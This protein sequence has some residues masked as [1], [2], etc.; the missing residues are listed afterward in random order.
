MYVWISKWTVLLFMCSVTNNVTSEWCV[1][2]RTHSK[3]GIWNQ[4][5][6][7]TRLDWNQSC[8]NMHQV[9]KFCSIILQIWEQ[10]LFTLPALFLSQRIFPSYNF[11]SR[12]TFFAYVAHSAGM[13]VVRV[14]TGIWSFWPLA[15]LLCRPLS[16]PRS[17]SSVLCC[18]W[19]CISYS[20]WLLPWLSSSPHQ[21]CLR[22]G[23]SGRSCVE[24]WEYLLFKGLVPYAVLVRGEQRCVFGRGR[25]RADTVSL[26]GRASKSHSRLPPHYLFQSGKAQARSHRSSVCVCAWVCGL[27]FVLVSTYVYICICEVLF[28]VWCVCIFR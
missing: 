17:P 1:D 22:T 11:P 28:I 8:E 10:P 4:L 9:M 27:A 3:T 20:S 19:T 15:L 12:Q 6:V 25:C 26:T 24:T 5:S 16:P 14:Y 21:H 13:S 18:V 23:I 2:G 7:K